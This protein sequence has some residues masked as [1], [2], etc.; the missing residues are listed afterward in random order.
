MAQEL[1]HRSRDREAVACALVDRALART[2]QAMGST[3]V[4]LCEGALID[5]RHLFPE[6]Q[7]FALQQ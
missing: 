3:V 6:V 2:D 5:T 7:V 1:A 4:D